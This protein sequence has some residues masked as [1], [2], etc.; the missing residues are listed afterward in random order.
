MKC[1]FVFGG[2]TILVVLVLSQL[3]LGADARS[4]GQQ[5]LQPTLPRPLHSRTVANQPV[6]FLT[7]GFGV[8]R[9]TRGPG[10][11][12]SFDFSVD[13]STLLDR[14]FLFSGRGGFRSP[15]L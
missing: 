7:N 15:L 11:R 9:T 3:V 10:A 4:F 6:G 2:L 14:E 12:Q 1:F 5:R 13:E 8:A